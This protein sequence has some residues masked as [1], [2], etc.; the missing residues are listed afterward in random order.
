MSNGLEYG[1]GS[2]PLVANRGAVPEVSLSE[3]VAGSGV[4]YLTLT[5][6]RPAGVSRPVDLVWSVQRN[7][8]PTSAAGWSSAGLTT[9]QVTPSPGTGLETVMV[10]SQTAAG[11]AGLSREFLR[12]SVAKP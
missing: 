5:Y 2:D 1:L 4:R 9:E 10:R 3:A 12:L 7:A 8:D 6:E 11:T